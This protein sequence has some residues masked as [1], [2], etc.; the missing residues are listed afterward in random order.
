MCDPPGRG[1][2]RA[3]GE[4]AIRRRILIAGVGT[5]PAVARRPAGRAVIPVLV[6]LA[7]GQAAPARKLIPAGKLIPAWKARPGR[8]ASARPPAS[9][10]R[11]GSSVRP[12]AARA[13]AG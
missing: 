5:A 8:K 3:G 10:S 9:S 2:R 1:V 6:A 13:M 4:V 11:P 12:F 7:R